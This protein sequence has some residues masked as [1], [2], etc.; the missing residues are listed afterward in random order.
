MSHSSIIQQ[1]SWPVNHSHRGITSA[2]LMLEVPRDDIRSE[3]R[4]FL[5]AC[6]WRQFSLWRATPGPPRQNESTKVSG[7]FVLTG[8]KGRDGSEVANLWGSWR[9]RSHD[10]HGPRGAW[11]WTT[12]CLVFY[13]LWFTGLESEEEEEHHK[14]APDWGFE[15]YCTLAQKVRERTLDDPESYLFLCIC[16]FSGWSGK[17]CPHT[18][19][20]S[21]QQR[22]SCFLSLSLTPAIFKSN[23]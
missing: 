17:S 5:R 20:S 21:C 16:C 1:H 18:L 13:S 10:D 15:S 22:W 23:T 19:S 12:T 9:E 11:D 3:G 2:T 6:E 4:G 8:V 14:S 7:G